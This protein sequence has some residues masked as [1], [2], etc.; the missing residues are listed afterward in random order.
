MQQ[1]SSRQVTIE[2]RL[3]CD[4]LVPE[5][6]SAYA[7]LFSKMKRTLFADYCKG[8]SLNSLKNAYLK[9]FG[10]TARQFNACRVELE[11]KINSYKEQ[12]LLQITETKG[13]IQATEK[14]IRLVKRKDVKHQLKRRL[15][16]LTTNLK[17]LQKEF[18]EKK[19][20]LCFG[21]KSLFLKQFNLEKNGYSSIE[22]WKT[23]W[24][25]R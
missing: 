17:T 14:R 8:H 19:V 11:G 7:K 18:L 20:R 15:R 2:T 5:Q 9:K 4:D 22:E 16:K 13:R 21:G 25:S 3:D 1:K 10:V 6:L 12:I 24:Q 23:D